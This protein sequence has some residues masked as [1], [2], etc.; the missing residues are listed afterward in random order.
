MV[1]SVIEIGI[2]TKRGESP[3]NVKSVDAVK[4][5][6]LVNNRHFSDNN[7]KAFQI[8]LIEIEN[9]KYY[10]TITKT[11]IPAID[12]R[13]NIIVE[14]VRLN[15]LVG[16]EFFIG[17]VK[18]KAHDLCRPCKYLQDYLKQNN[19]IK[20]LLL[21]AGIRCEILNDGKINVGDEI[22]Y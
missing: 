11:N 20:E 3:F 6:G 19:L 7:N 8:T 17:N 15:N 1:G 12:F 14:G 5:K 18:I 9:I 2:H 22:K 16:K 13:R 10:N 4:G 21:K